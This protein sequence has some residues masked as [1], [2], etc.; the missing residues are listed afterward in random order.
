[1]IVII[2]LSPIEQLTR[3]HG[4]VKLGAMWF[5]TSLTLPHYL[6]NLIIVL[7][8][9]VFQLLLKLGLHYHQLFLGFS[10]NL[11]LILYRLCSNCLQL[12]VPLCTDLI[13]DPVVL[14]PEGRECNEWLEYLKSGRTSK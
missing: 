2:I 1:M 4:A 13:E 6:L 11:Q 10:N 3:A 9:D 7:L 14:L 8:P 12:S 5:S